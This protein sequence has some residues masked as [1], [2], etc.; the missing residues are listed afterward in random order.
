[1]EFYA[2]YTSTIMKNVSIF[3][4]KIKDK[5]FWRVIECSKKNLDKLIQLIQDHNIAY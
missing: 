3:A 1:M 5:S 2:I 4:K